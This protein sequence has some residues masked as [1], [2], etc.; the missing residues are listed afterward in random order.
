LIRFSN[1]NMQVNR[2]YVS[3][4]SWGVNKRTS[5]SRFVLRKKVYESL[6]PGCRRSSW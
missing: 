1:Q 2:C 5:T 3:G 4:R 6:I